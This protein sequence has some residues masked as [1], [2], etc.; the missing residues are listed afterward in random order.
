ML[1]A[2][3]VPAQAKLGRGAQL[4]LGRASLPEEISDNVGR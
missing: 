2:L 1:G 4:G 3:E